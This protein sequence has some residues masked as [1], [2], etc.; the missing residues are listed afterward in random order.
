VEWP[1]VKFPDGITSTERE[2]DARGTLRHYRG[3]AI[4]NNSSTTKAVLTRPSHGV[5]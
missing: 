3:A 2:A 1:V 4:L 5:N